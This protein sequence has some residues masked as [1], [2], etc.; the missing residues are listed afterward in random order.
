MNKSF[1]RQFPRLEG[2][3]S[4]CNSVLHTQRWASFL[5][6]EH[7]LPQNHVKVCWSN[8]SIRLL[9]DMM[10]QV[11]HWVCDASQWRDGQS[12]LCWPW[13]MENRRRWKWSWHLLFQICCWWVDFDE[14]LN[15][16][17]W[18]LWYLTGEKEYNLKME[19]LDRPIF[20]MGEDAKIVE[21]MCKYTVNGIPGWGI[22]EWDYRWGI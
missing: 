17:S 16:L 6:W 19:V 10:R 20:F 5:C 22:S 21:R 14:F 13:A 9:Y 15:F 7:L 12:V 3:P 2:S 18:M 1:Y 4:L 8:Y 11:D